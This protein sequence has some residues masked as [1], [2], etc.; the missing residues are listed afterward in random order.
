MKGKTQ[1]F[2]SFASGLFVV[3][4]PFLMCNCSGSGGD[5][6][7]S[8]DFSKLVNLNENYPGKLF[9]S[10]PNAFSADTNGNFYILDKK[11]HCI[12][13]FDKKGKLVRQIDG[14]SE[15]CRGLTN[16][17]GFFL[18]EDTLY[19]LN[20]FGKKIKTMTLDGASLNEFS[21]PADS[22]AESLSVD[23]KYIYLNTQT[24]DRNNYTQAKLITIYTKDGVAVKE[25]GDLIKTIDYY[26]YR[27]FNQ[28]YITAVDGNVFVAPLFVPIIKVYNQEGKKILD[29]DLRKRNIEDIREKDLIAE[30]K[31]TD[32]PE[33]A[34]GPAQRGV[35]YCNGLAGSANGHLYYST[36]YKILH[37]DRDFKLLEIIGLSGNTKG[38][39][40]FQIS[41]GQD[42]KVSGLVL[43]QSSVYTFNF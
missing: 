2:V 31:M 38:G 36:G 7:G 16:P 34:S 33:T 5:L 29:L 12:M 24:F 1:R 10:I 8:I 25:I 41:T 23:E 14:G 40:F 30:E 19:A 26:G 37:F 3:I 17:I 42:G 18:H 22:Y 6:V 35:R 13:V 15:N 20:D 43:K 27:M 32:T 39:N 4:L 28:C 9:T 21:L 11:N